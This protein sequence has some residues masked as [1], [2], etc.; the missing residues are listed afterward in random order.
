MSL[1]LK[2][3][4]F[5][6]DGVLFDSRKA[7]QEYYNY[8]LKETGRAPLTEEE[9]HF[10]HMHSLPECLDFLFRN[11]PELKERALRIARETSY[12]DFFSFMKMEEGLKEFLEWAA[13][14]F[15]LALCTN[16]TTSTRPL[17]QFFDLERYFH[18]I[19]TALEVPKSD[20]QALR[21][22]LEYFRVLPEEALFIGDS[23]IDEALALS[24]GVP[25]ISFKN[26]NLKA[27]KVVTSFAELRAFLEGK[28]PLSA[29]FLA[30]THKSS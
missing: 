4:V 23:V 6:C 15:Y 2:L 11:H 17:L 22:I 3:L 19:R 9:L 27:L 7:N 25:L 26:P 20:P 30:S 5:D 10:V 21:S 28:D 13:F 24:C 12:S 18:L 29:P 14:N 16:R 1:S 8:L